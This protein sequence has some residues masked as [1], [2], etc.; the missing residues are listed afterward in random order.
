MASKLYNTL[1]T[2][3]E[4]RLACIQNANAVGIQL[5]NNANLFSIADS[6]KQ[7]NNAE[8]LYNQDP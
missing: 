4:G 8:H 3:N 7:L 6:F 5:N 1:N 2:L